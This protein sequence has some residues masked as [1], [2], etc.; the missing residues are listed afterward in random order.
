MH[1][2]RIYEHPLLPQKIVKMGFSWPAFLLGPWW[3]LFK[4]LWTPVA[5][6]FAVTAV[7]YFWNRSTTDPF[8]AYQFCSVDPNIYFRG[9]SYTEACENLRSGYEFLILIGVNLAVALNGNSLWASDLVNRGYIHRRTI[10]SRSLDELRAILARESS[11]FAL[12]QPRHVAQ[13]QK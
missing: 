11:E 5:I 1:T 2:F 6:V 9:V 10:Q 7:L 8:F 3:L 13:G 4:K 12:T